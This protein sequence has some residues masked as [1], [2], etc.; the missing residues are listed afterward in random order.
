MSPSQRP[1]GRTRAYHLGSRTRTAKPRD[2]R[3]GGDPSV[4]PCPVY[5]GDR[6]SVSAWREDPGAS[7]SAGISLLTRLP[8]R[9]PHTVGLRSTRW[10]REARLG[11]GPA[12]ALH[13]CQP[14]SPVSFSSLRQTP[15]ALS[16]CPEKVQRPQRTVQKHTRHNPRPR[17]GP[18]SSMRQAATRNFEP[19]SNGPVR[20]WGFTRSSAG[21]GAPG[22]M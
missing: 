2:L 4:P 7:V 14:L 13:P 17:G 9:G 3:Q 20:W 6:V 8:T 16:R 19:W 1:A 15:R 18:P 21:P 5:D 10:A 11:V 12:G 22:G